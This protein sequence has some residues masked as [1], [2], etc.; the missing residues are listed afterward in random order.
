[1]RKYGKDPWVINLEGFIEHQWVHGVV[2][3]ALI[4]IFDLA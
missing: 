3:D 1:M 4:V 2:L